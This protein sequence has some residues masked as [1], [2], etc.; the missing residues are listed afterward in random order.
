MAER[1]GDE[2]EAGFERREAMNGDAEEGDDDMADDEVEDDDCGGES[3]FDG[4]W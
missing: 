2:A 4:K 3:A 1:Q